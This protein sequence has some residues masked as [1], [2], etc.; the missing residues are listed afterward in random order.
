MTAP[1]RAALAVCRAW[2]EHFG[3]PGWGSAE[4]V[5]TELHWATL[6]VAALL[7]EP[8]EAFRVYA[9]TRLAIARALWVAE[10][11][12]PDAPE[13]DALPRGGHEQLSTLSRADTMAQELSRH[14]APLPVSVA[15][16][17][18]EPEPWRSEC[19]A[20][21]VELDIRAPHAIIALGKVAPAP[22]DEDVARELANA[23][24]GHPEYSVAD[25]EAA[26]HYVRA[27]RAAEQRVREVR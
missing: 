10:H 2:D 3:E 15:A 1:T 19:P 20:C 25:A 4:Y 8:S 11:G 26:S 24:A 22:A 13:W 18:R 27:V 7:R 17:L 14:I 12:Y 5:Q 16:L 23:L 6:A 21:G 9:S